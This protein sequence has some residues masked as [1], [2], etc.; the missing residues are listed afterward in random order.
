MLL[1]VIGI[2]I[3]FVALLVATYATSLNLQ[4]HRLKS[5]L[6]LRGSFSLWSSVS[7]EDKYVGSVTIQNLKD[8]AVIL[9]KIFLQIGHNYYVELEDFTNQPVTLEPFGI[10]HREYD[11]IDHYSSGT[12]RVHL[13][14]LLDAKGVRRRLVLATSDGRYVIR[15]WIRRWDAVHLFF[16]N[17]YTSII[18]PLRSTYKGKAYGS[19][20]KY[21]V[22]I[23]LLDG[24]EEVI[25]IHAHDYRYR[26][27]R[28]FQLTSDVLLSAVAL[29]EFLLER[30]IA[31]DLN[32]SDVSV[33]DME[34]W[35]KQSYNERD[36]EPFQAPKVGW[37]TY[38]IVG[39]LRTW[40][41]N[42]QMHRQNRALEK[43]R[44]AATRK[45]ARG[46]T[47]Q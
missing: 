43:K 47:P 27:F 23:K 40:W 19:N 41:D 35:R 36:M 33:V 6:E 5:G 25:P 42:W 3:G 9:F 14:D 37:I 32:C 2:A 39:R 18:R 10:L 8:R 24:K 4:A 34:N 30:A 17:H 45:A 29:E 38:H 12:H 15:H 28:K 20:A 7:C 11:P 46:A 22:N 21:V 1:Q 13:N 26:I 31:G 44:L 16:K